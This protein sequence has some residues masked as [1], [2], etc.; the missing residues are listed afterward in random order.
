[1]ESKPS[2][3]KRLALLA[4]LLRP[5]I[6]MYRCFQVVA[7]VAVI[8]HHPLAA[9]GQSMG[10]RVWAKRAN[11]PNNPVC[12]ASS[13]DGSHL[14]ALAYPTGIYTST[15]F[16]LDWTLQTNAPIVTAQWASIVSSSDGS[17][18][19]A[20]S[21]LGEIYTSAN[22]GISWT[23]QTIAPGYS[24]WASIASSSDGSHLAVALAAGGI[25]T[26]TNFGLNWT[27]QLNIESSVNP[28]SIASSSDGSRLVAAFEGVAGPGIYTSTNFGL[29]WTF[30]TN[31]PEW[32]ASW[33]A[34][35]SSADGSHLV[36]A[37]GDIYTSA[38]FGRN[39]TRQ[40]NA[41]VSSWR[42]IA[43]SS[44]GSH[45]AAAA[46]SY[47][48]GVYTSANFGLDW[49]FQNVTDSAASVASSADGSYLAAVATDF[50]G[51]YTSGPTPPLFIDGSGNQ[52]SVYW[53]NTVPCTLQQN[54]NFNTPSGWT[55]ISNGV[56]A[57]NG[58]NSLSI[59]NPA[60][61]LFF[62]LTQ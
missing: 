11:A 23:L 3:T 61:T 10:Q 6:T 15:N 21:I 52:V 49:T 25:Y 57:A 39:W 41:P 4:L 5:G 62:R 22:F 50:E 27:L 20:V 40:T 48:G 53:P 34:V 35:A 47:G 36:A 17:H 1:M 13:G 7:L 29:D 2:V 59:T 16:G 51:L 9:R 18:L 45:L 37:D 60:G 8:F 32:W 33:W 46:L 43:S 58:T 44:D 19:A 56:V 14:A 12:V 55:P 54:T 38:D 31:A 42:S 30:Q 24:Q 26:S 28:C